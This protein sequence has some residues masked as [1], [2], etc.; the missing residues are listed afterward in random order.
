MSRIIQN[1]HRLGYWERKPIPYLITNCT[2]SEKA[3][4]PCLVIALS[5]RNLQLEIAA[6]QEGAFKTVRFVGS[7]WLTQRSK[8]VSV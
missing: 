4:L 3:L 6:E 1:V 8:A 2:V 5:G 7:L